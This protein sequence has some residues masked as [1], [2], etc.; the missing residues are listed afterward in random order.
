VPHGLFYL[1]RAVSLTYHNPETGSQQGR[2]AGIHAAAGGGAGSANGPT[3][4]GRRRPHIV[5]RLPGKF[6]GQFISFF[7]GVHQSPVGGVTG[8][9]D[10]PAQ[11]QAVTGDKFIYYV[12]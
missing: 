6:K 4:P 11:Q 2:G 1:R 3:R 5:Q 8:S 10:D 7:Q 12:K 9:I